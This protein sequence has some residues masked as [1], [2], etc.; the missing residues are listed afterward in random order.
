MPNQPS[1]TAIRT[2]AVKPAI[3]IEPLPSTLP[4]TVQRILIDPDGGAPLRCCLRNSRAGERI[5]L[6]SVTPPG[7][8]GAYAESGPVFVHTDGCAGPESTGY[9]S[10][11]RSRSQVFRAYSADGAI[12]G[13]EIVE[14]GTGQEAVAERLLADASVAFLHSRNVIHGCYMFAIRRAGE[15]A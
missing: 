13:G 3:V 5:T 2:T 1:T 8:A 15:S 11:F 4:I 14:P 6:G 10:E 12:V 7:P 9:P